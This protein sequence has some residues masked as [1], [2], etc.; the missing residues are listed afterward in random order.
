MEPR[1][2]ALQLKFSDPHAATVHAGD[3][4]RNVNIYFNGSSFLGWNEIAEW[5]FTVPYCARTATYLSAN[6]SAPVSLRATF[7]RVCFCRVNFVVACRQS[8]IRFGDD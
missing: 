5:N 2:V 1:V 8:G 3:A 4:I 7:A 6:C